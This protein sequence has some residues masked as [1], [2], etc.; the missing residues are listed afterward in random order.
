MISASSGET[1]IVTPG[2]PDGQFKSKAD[3][4]L[5]GEFYDMPNV[6]NDYFLLTFQIIDMHDGEIV[7]EGSYEV[8]FS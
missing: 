2:S 6:G 3:Y 1:T 4:A 7:F 5:R 8:K